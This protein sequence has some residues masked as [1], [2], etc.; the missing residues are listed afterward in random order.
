LLA[1]A[2]SNVAHYAFSF[3]CQRLGDSSIA[4]I[5]REPLF[6]GVYD[7][8]ARVHGFNSP[9]CWEARHRHKIKS[10]KV[11]DEALRYP[12]TV[13]PFSIFFFDGP[14]VFVGAKDRALNRHR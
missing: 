4:W 11:I 12:A 13:I 1:L 14:L 7:L 10:N 3:K 2:A 6:V 8:E 9:W 5:K